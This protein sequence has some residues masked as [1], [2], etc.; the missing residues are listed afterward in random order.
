MAYCQWINILL[1]VELP[2]D[3]ILRL[4]TEA[5]WEKAARSIDGRKYPWG[6]TFDK[7]KC[8]TN[9]GGKGHTTRVGLY[10]PRGDSP[11]GC[12]DMV[13]NVWEWTH[14]LKRKYP[15]K[16]YDGRENENSSDARVIRGGS[17]A[18]NKRRARCCC[19]AHSNF[20][21]SEDGFGFR[22]CIAP[23]LPK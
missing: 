21:S 23:P 16:V 7:S 1:K 14:S 22:I 17:F 5:E 9:E 18:L 10:S 3:L 19:R 12:T 6:N 20:N 2:S 4:P 13:G 15:Y 8:N 11:Y